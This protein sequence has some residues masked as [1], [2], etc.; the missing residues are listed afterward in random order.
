MGGDGFERVEGIVADLRA[1]LRNNDLR[2]ISD[3]LAELRK[4]PAESAPDRVAPTGEP[5][6]KR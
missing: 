1:A 4:M 2:G 6:A 3:K 5:K